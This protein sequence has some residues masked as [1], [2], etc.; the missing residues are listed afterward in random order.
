LSS[1][2]LDCRET[3]QADF[4]SFR[5]DRDAHDPALRHAGLHLHVEAGHRAHRVVA[6]LLQ[7]PDLD[8]PKGLS[9]TRHG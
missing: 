1:G 9:D 6:G 4:L 3:A 2:E 5:A 7:V 8:Q